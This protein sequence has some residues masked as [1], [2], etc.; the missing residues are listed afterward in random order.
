MERDERWAADG[1]GEMRELLDGSRWTWS[2]T[3]ASRCLALACLLPH[4]RS[5]SMLPRISHL[6]DLKGR[7]PG[8][9]GSSTDINTA[10][11]PTAAH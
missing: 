10:K 2:H 6:D 9:N 5:P 8:D 3:V 7:R 11:G 1:M 4:R